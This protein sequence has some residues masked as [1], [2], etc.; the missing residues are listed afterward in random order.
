MGTLI[1]HPENKE[2]IISFKPLNKNIENL[3]LDI[4]TAL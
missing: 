3:V 1:A 2:K 4:T